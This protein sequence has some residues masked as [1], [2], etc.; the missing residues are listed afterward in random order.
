MKNCIVFHTTEQLKDWQIANY[1]TSQISSLCEAVNN[2]DNPLSYYKG[3]GSKA[4]N[5]YLRKLLNDDDVKEMTYKLQELINQYVT[6][7]N[8]IVYRFVKLQE[9][10]VLL[11]STFCKKI[12]IVPGF[13]S[14]TFLPALYSMEDIKK[15]SIRI[16]IIVPKDTH[17]I[18]IP[19]VNP[20]SPEYEWLMPYGMKLKRLSLKTYIVVP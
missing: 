6:N 9:L 20:D 19:E 3:E 8:F 7:D 2:M 15:A 13:L 4:M 16:K 1:S 10:K 11:K 17:G 18:C 12:Y 5:R 14:T